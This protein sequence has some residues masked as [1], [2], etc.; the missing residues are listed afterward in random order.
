MGF[1]EAKHEV[2]NKSLDIK[3]NKECNND[4]PEMMFWSLATV[5]KLNDSKLVY[6]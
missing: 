2:I 6:G 4:R 1:Y 3:S 5:R